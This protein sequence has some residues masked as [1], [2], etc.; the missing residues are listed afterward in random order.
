MKKIL[1]L[2]IS[3]IMAMSVSFGQDTTQVIQDTT[4]VSQ[5]TTQVSQS[6]API[7]T[8]PVKKE[9]KKAP[10]NQKR[11]YFGG[12]IG[13]S[14]GSYTRIGLYPLIGFKLTPKFSVGVQIKYEYIKDSRY[15]EG[16]ETSN[17][18]GSVFTRYR[19]IPRLYVHAEYEMMNYGLYN[20]T[21]DLNRDWVTFL[22]LGGG[23]SQPIG[24]NAWLNAQVLFDVLQNENSPYKAWQ[25]FFSVGVGV[26]F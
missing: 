15:T 14:F 4:Q 26:G 19:I 1:L 24:G 8:E 20:A 9:K 22:Y 2:F 11:V 25:P 21:G 12:N 5:D 3:V 7:A 17:Y 10:S 18:G 13:L 6:T 23:F 16:R